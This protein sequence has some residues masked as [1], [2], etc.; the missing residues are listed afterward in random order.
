MYT[1]SLSRRQI[2]AS[3][4]ASCAC[5]LRAARTPIAASA[6]FAAVERAVF[7]Q[8]TDTLAVLMPGEAEEFAAIAARIIPSDETPGATEAGAIYFIDR[9]LGS[10]HAELL[11][12]LREGLSSLQS[13]A[14][15]AHGNPQFS[16]M[17]PAEQDELLRQIESSPFF[18]LM[19]F[20][21]ICGT[22]ASPEYGGNRDYVGWQLI[23]FDHRHVWQ[24]PYGYY[25]A[26]Y[27]QSGE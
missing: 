11:P 15:A 2:L 6:L 20:L 12:A 18:L 17:A 13:T 14:R 19:R 21:T 16:A 8:T 3:S 24:A 10:S 23:G 22:F 26:D 4:L 9:V 7:A 27:S 5:A 25:D 1:R